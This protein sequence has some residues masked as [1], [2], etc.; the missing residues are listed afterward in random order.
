MAYKNDFIIERVTNKIIELLEN[1]E[2]PWRRPWTINGVLPTNLISGV[3]YRGANAFFL[4]LSCYNF[5]SPYF[6]TFKQVK[7]LGGSVKKGEHSIPVIYWNWREIKVEKEGE[8]EEETKKIPF[9]KSYNVFNVEQCTG[10][11]V[12]VP[13]LD[14]T[15]GGQGLL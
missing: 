3:A 14:V 12:Q 8:E 9:M 11:S 15:W 1:G 13:P 7:K 4:S 2:V 5:Q 6:L 10:I